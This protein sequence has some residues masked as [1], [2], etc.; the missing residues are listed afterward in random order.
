VPTAANGCAAFGHYRPDGHGGHTPWA[1]VVVETDGKLITGLHCH[2]FP[3]LFAFF[4][5]PPAL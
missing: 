4:G 2:L 3:E 5:F 1:I